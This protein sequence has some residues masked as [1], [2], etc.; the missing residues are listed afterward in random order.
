MPTTSNK[1]RIFLKQSRNSFIQWVPN[2][3]QHAIVLLLFWNHPPCIYFRNYYKMLKGTFLD[4]N[5]CAYLV[6]IRI[7]LVAYFP[8]TFWVENRSHVS[9]NTQIK[10]ALCVNFFETLCPNVND[11]VA[12]NLI[13]IKDSETPWGLLAIYFSVSEMLICLVL[14]AHKVIMM[15]RFIPNCYCLRYVG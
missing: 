13:S 12:V 8:L 15:M 6:C 9:N 7:A 10:S 11:T 1:K 4:G 14:F 5:W 2:V 3:S